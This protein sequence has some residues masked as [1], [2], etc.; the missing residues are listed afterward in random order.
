MMY[1][2]WSGRWALSIRLADMTFLVVL[3]IVFLRRSTYR[4]DRRMLVISAAFL[5]QAVADITYV[6]SGA[7]R[8][9]AEAQP[10]F[11]CS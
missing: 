7:G 2:R 9:F 11:P 8:T 1:R 6:V 10:L 3:L 4:F 5:V